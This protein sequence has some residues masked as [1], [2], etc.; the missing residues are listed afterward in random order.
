MERHSS[1]FISQRFFLLVFR[2]YFAIR[3][4]FLSEREVES[5]NP[6]FVPRSRTYCSPEP[7]RSLLGAE[8]APAHT[9]NEFISVENCDYL[10]IIS[11][12]SRHLTPLFL[13]FRCKIFCFRLYFVRFK[14][15]SELA[16]SDNLCLFNVLLTDLLT[17]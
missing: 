9:K 8:E 3:R 17:K 7:S 10:G 5:D 12:F 15:K 2:L 4:Y 1:C 6:F 16:E 13:S 14:K 11:A